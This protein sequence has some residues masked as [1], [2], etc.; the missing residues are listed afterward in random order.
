MREPDG[1]AMSSRNVYLS[2]PSRE[3]ATVLYRALLA[4]RATLDAPTTWRA[5]P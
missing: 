2:G 1:L 5:R 3:A 4:G